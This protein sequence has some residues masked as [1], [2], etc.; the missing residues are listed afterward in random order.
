MLGVRPPFLLFLSPL[1]RDLPQKSGVNT[2]LLA[3][4]D[5][6]RIII[7][8]TM[9]NIVYQLS[10]IDNGF[11]LQKNSN[12]EWETVWNCA[13]KDDLGV[14][15]TAT[16]SGTKTVSDG[17]TIADVSISAGTWLV[18]GYAGAQ[19]VRIQDNASNHMIYKAG[20]NPQSV[21]TVTATTNLQ[22]VNISGSD[23]SVWAD[24]TNYYLVAMRLK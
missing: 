4:N 21:I 22:L 5:S 9:D 24:A 2:V 23:L 8:Y 17:G 18:W 20:I 1:N 6:E 15:K 10:A 11:R 14:T 13:L 12:N 3:N 7:R 16:A 19:K